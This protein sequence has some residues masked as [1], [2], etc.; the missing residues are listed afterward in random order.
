MLIT[1]QSGG[2]L[3]SV[4]LRLGLIDSVSIGGKDTSTIIDGPSFSMEDE[5]QKIKTLELKTCKKLDNSYLHLI[6]KVNN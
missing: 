1:I 4:L 2:T 5:L 3:N 6:Y